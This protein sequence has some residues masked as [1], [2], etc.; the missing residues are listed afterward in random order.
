MR[1]QNLQF[2]VRLSAYIVWRQRNGNGRMVD[3]TIESTFW[4]ARSWAARRKTRSVANFKRNEN[5]NFFFLVILYSHA[6]GGLIDF[7]PHFSAQRPG[8]EQYRK[9]RLIPA[10]INGPTGE[11]GR[12]VSIRYAAQAIKTTRACDMRV[13][14]LAH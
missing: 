6:F 5:V 14:H 4:V 2:C 9:L 11:G 3:A 13:W 10:R 7:F 1:S 8:E 12:I